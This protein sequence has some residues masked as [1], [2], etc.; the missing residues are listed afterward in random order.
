MPRARTAWLANYLTTGFFR[1][2]HEFLAR[3]PSIEAA[4][5]AMLAQKIGISDSGAVWFQRRLRNLVPDAKWVVITRDTGD[6]SESLEEACD[7]PTD[8]SRHAEKVALACHIP[9]ALVVDFEDIDE[10]VVE[11]AR[12]AFPD[13]VHDVDRH[14]QLLSLSIQLRKPFLKAGIRAVPASLLEQ[15]EP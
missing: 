12:F 8:L 14:L 7:F 1:C 13:W 9:G 6:A 10:R 3:Y 2:R 4:V 11:I 5:A 15:M